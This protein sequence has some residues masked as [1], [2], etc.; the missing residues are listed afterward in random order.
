[1]TN[2]ATI[3]ELRSWIRNCIIQEG[4]KFDSNEKLA[5]MVQERDKGCTYLLF[6][7]DP[8]ME[9]LMELGRDFPMMSVSDFAKSL[10][11]SGM[12]EQLIGLVRCYRPYRNSHWGASEVKLSAAE[13]G[14][15]PTM[16]DIAMSEEPRGLMADRSE[17]SAEAYG[18]WEYYLKNRDDVDKKPLDSAFHQWTPDS[19]DDGFVGS[20]GDYA[21]SEHP[22]S[23][24]EFLEDATC[25]V[26]SKEP[27]P[28]IDS[29]KRNG[30]IIKGALISIIGADKLETFVKKISYFGFDYF[31]DDH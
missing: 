28:T 10:I 26:Y 22:E 7:L 8:T 23:H 5:L 1:M 15:G 2:K 18:V 14:W 27:V 9:Y 20:A 4:L 13:N 30:E 11:Y 17:V 16:Y 6:R 25:W 29:W 21:K 3:S 12:Q 31:N 24:E 19:Y